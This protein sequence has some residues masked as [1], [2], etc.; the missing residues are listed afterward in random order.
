MFAQNHYELSVDPYYSPY[1]GSDW[2][3]SLHKGLEKKEDSLIK[4]ATPPKRGV[5]PSLGRGLEITLLWFPVN[6]FADV[7]Q[8]EVFGHGY[9]ARS[10]G[11]S[12]KGYTFD[13]PF[14]YG[15]GG[16]ATYWEP[17]YSTKVGEF[18]AINIAG[19]ESEN[20]L[21]RQLKLKW[22]T[23]R[24]LN[25]K[26]KSLYELAQLSPLLYSL[27]DVP[28]KE[29]TT[30]EEKEPIHPA[31]V[32]HDVQ[33]YL[34]TLNLMYPDDFLSLQRLRGELYWNLLD[35]MIYYG[36]AAVWYYSITGK[37]LYIPMF[38]IGP[39]SFLP[40]ISVQLAPYGLEYYL[41]NYLVYK[42]SPVY[43]YVK[44]GEHAFSQYFGCGIHYDEILKKELFTAGLRVDGW[45][46][47]NILFGWT[48]PEFLENTRPLSTF[49]EACESKLGMAVSI[50]SRFLIKNS[51]T[52]LY[53]DIGYKT[54][55]YL[56]GFPLQRSPTLRLGISAE[57]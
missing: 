49:D 26:E 5:L 53:S 24:R 18:Q 34:N 21:A 44:W 54:E 31:L 32:G 23:T 48:F 37:D 6:A 13:A 19:L 46:Q 29:K 15:K 28:K 42:D 10:L 1:M 20:I 25:P 39:I 14:P 41:E 3:L 8:H 27:A 57:F 12:V 4:P 52:F 30:E 7:I 45:Y 2:I 17:K 43:T 50:V 16:G 22:L 56:P 33:A 55:G 47:P 51:L 38:K 9:R 35:P 40:N 11:F 36:I